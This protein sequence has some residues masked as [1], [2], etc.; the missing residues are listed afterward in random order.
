MLS[1]NSLIEVLQLSF[2]K[3][4]EDVVLETVIHALLAVVPGANV[5]TIL[6]YGILERDIFFA[7]EN[8]VVGG[9]RK[10]CTGEAN[11]NNSSMTPCNHI[12][13]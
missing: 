8:D 5:P 9:H 3:M 4:H 1:T 2:S 12:A 6:Y 10:G 11:C 7:V 13:N